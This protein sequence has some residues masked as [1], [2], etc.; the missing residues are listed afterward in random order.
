MNEQQQENVRP[1]GRYDIVDA[2]TGFQVK[3]LTVIPGGKLSYQRH[4]QRSERWVVVRGAATVTLDDVVSEFRVGQVI[5]VPAM[6]KHR[7][8]N[9]E[10]SPLVII[11]VQLGHYLGEDDIE[12][13]EDAYGRT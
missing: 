10:D 13:F 4:K 2:D 12:R 11:E 8:E 6:A 7:I 3:R 5:F 1:W 9:R